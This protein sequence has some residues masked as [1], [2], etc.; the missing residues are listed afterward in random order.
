MLNAM[1]EAIARRA[2][3][4]VIAALED[5][6]LITPVHESLPLSVP[7]KTL[8]KRWGCKSRTIRDTWRKKKL[9]RQ[10]QNRD[11][12]LFTRESILRYELERNK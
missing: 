1:G 7:I 2:A 5:R 11:G 12:L 3:D 10:G 6:R 4:I 9:V 8:A